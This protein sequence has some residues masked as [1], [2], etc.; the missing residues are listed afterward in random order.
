MSLFQSI[1]YCEVTVPLPNQVLINLSRCH[2]QSFHGFCFEL[3]DGL[4]I[5][6]IFADHLQIQLADLCRSFAYSADL[7]R[8]FAYSADLC[9][10][11]AYSADL[12]RSLAVVFQES[13][14]FT[15]NL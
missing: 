4:Y 9:R 13:P 2:N 10:S 11:F 12:C 3:P 5:E 15:A 7:C 1:I 14:N 6:P 8:S